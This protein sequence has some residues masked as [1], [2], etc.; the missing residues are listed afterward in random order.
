MNWIK[1]KFLSRK[2]QGAVE[3]AMVTLA[4]VLIIVA[5]LFTGNTGLKGAITAA[6]DR[7]VLQINK[8]S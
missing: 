3:Y 8:A 6:F 2:G 5:V 4:I 7:A 1:S